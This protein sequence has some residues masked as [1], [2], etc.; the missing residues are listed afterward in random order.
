MNK[1]RKHKVGKTNTNQRGF[2][3]V[4]AVLILV[5]LGI[6][7]FSGY[8]VWHARQHTVPVASKKSSTAVSSK[9]AKS[10]SVSEPTGVDP[11]VGWNTYTSKFGFSLRYPSG[12]RVDDT[13]T[14]ATTINDTTGPNSVDVF[15]YADGYTEANCPVTN[16]EQFPDCLAKVEFTLRS[17][18]SADGVIVNSTTPQL[19]SKAQLVI[20]S[21]KKKGA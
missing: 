3:T 18:T 16:P 20:E 8:F 9:S 12:A 10:S 1:M 19:K 5:I 11:Y 14:G 13:T 2:S 6:V 21:Y 7:A 17:D 4:E 15:V